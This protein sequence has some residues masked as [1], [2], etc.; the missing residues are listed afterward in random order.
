VTG[1]PALTATIA[2]IFLALL[3]GALAPGAAAADDMAVKMQWDETLYRDEVSRVNLEITNINGQ[4]T[5]NVTS[6][7]LYIDWMRLGTFETNSSSFL[8]E[9]GQRKVMTIF[10]RVPVDARYGKHSDYVVIQY[11]L[12]NSSSGAWKNDTFESEINKDF[13]VQERPAP[14]QDWLALSF[15]NPLCVAGLAFAV[16]LVAVMAA[17]R[18]RRLRRLARKLEETIPEI[19]PEKESP[20]APLPPPEEKHPE[21]PEKCPFCGAPWPGKHCQNCGWDLE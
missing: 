2:G 9:N 5:M 16:I 15:T 12:Y 4:Y 7:G 21:G 13:S 20:P 14:A 1:K 10:F 11:A 18:F 6:A 17:R 19:P 3:L 8:I